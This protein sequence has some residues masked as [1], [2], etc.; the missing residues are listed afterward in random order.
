MS[1]KWAPD[2]GRDIQYKNQSVEQ[3]HRY[4][5]WTGCIKNDVFCGIVDVKFFGFGARD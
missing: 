5:L 2:G 3:V 1:R 4:K